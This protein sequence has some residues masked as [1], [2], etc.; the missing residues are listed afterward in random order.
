M[1]MPNSMIQTKFHTIPHGR[2]LLCV[3]LLGIGIVI[4]ITLKIQ[5]YSN[6]ISPFL[7]THPQ[8]EGGEGEATPLQT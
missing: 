6:L 4:S 5:G 2:C 1:D 8:R 7:P 3:M